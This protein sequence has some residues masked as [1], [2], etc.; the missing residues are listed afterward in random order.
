MIQLVAQIIISH[1]DT[2]SFFSIGSVQDDAA[3]VSALGGALASFAIE[4]GLSD[5]GAT[6]ANY[7][8]FQNGVLISKWLELGNY[9]PSLMI[10]IRDF[11]DLEQYHHMFLIDYGTL[12]ANKIISKFEKM[13]QMFL[14]PGIMS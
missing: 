1:E 3:L 13:Y 14:L 6:N 11:G 4:M 12:L 7:S 5:I 9:K 8:K 2:T 10:A